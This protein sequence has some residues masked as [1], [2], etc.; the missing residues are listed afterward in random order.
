[1]Y[2]VSRFAPDRLALERSEPVSSDAGR[3]ESERLALL[4]FV[5]VRLAKAKSELIS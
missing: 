3:Y 4:R 5:P 1:M 2:A